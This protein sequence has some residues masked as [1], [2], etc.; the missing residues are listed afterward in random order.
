[1][2]SAYSSMIE[3]K[4]K[5]TTYK[6]LADTASSLFE[7]VQNKPAEVHSN[8]L[9]ISEKKNKTIQANAEARVQQI[10]LT[11]RRNAQAKL[12]ELSRFVVASG[13]IPSD[14]V[15]AYKVQICLGLAE[16]QQASAVYLK[17]QNYLSTL[18]QLSDVNVFQN[19]CAMAI[20]NNHMA[21]ARQTTNIFNSLLS[22]IIPFLP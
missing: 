3:A 17:Q 9:E 20:A 13:T 5:E 19:Q 6:L 15:N 22:H 8:S 21:N 16:C 14:V 2:Q 10:L 4:K 7:L 18:N 11:Q 12:S 1:M